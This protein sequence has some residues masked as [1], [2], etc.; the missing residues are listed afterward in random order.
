MG[1]KLQV[2]HRGFNKFDDFFSQ[3]VRGGNRGEKYVFH[4]QKQR[5]TML[6]FARGL[7]NSVL[8][9]FLMV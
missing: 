8:N 5:V 1:S 4:P 7:E 3:N 2:E 9:V 6:D